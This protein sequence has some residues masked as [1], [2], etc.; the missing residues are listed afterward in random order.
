VTIRRNVNLVE[1]RVRAIPS[2]AETG[3]KRSLEGKDILK[4]S[5]PQSEE[6][7]NGVC[8]VIHGKGKKVER[9]VREGESLYANEQQVAEEKRIGGDKG[10]KALY[11]EHLEKGKNTSIRSPSCLWVS[12]GGRVRRINKWQQSPWD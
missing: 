12:R 1:L 5:L 7:E 2:K 9:Q 3:K 10:K 4:G 8:G 6:R 11:D